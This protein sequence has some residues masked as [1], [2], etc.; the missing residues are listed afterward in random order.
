MRRLDAFCGRK[1]AACVS[2]LHSRHVALSLLA[3]LLLTPPVA[4][5]ADQQDVD[6]RACINA[7]HKAGMDVAKAVARRLSDCLRAGQSGALPSGQT[8]Q[9][10]L[11]ADN[12]GRLATATA[13]TIE[14]ATEKC[15]VAPDF[16]PLDPAAVNDAFSSLAYAGLLFGPDLDAA[17]AAAGDDSDRTGCQLAV[18]KRAGRT[19]A[20]RLKLFRSCVQRGLSRGTITDASGIGRCFAATKGDYGEPLVGGGEKVSDRCSSVDLATVLPGS[21]ALEPAA[22]LP[23]CADQVA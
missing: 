14:A 7:L 11:A 6:Q 4:A 2:Y 10:C 18:A 23:A 17:I 8:A 12:S 20:A 1:T 21:C 3:L 22:T 5:S 15:S 19:T 13:R 16:G 9:E